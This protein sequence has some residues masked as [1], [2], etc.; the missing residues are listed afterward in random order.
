MLGFIGALTQVQFAT[1]LAV[2]LI[3]L[4]AT[5]VKIFGEQEVWQMKIVKIA[6]ALCLPFLGII[7]IWS[8]VLYGRIISQSKG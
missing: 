5:L 3:I 4:I 1:L 6:M 7:I 2:Y 8:S